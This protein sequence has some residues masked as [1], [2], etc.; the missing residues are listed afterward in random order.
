MRKVTFKSLSIRNFLSVGDSPVVIDFKDGINL[1]TGRNLDKPDAKNGAGKSTIID[2]LYFALFGTTIRE[3]KKDLIVN[4]I[5]K[6]NCEVELSIAIENGTETDEYLI[7]RKINPSKCELYLNGVDATKSTIANTTDFIQKLVKSSGEVFKNSVIMTINNTTPFLAQ[8][9]IEK[10]KFVENVV[11]LEVFSSMLKSARDEYNE[12]R[13]TYETIYTRRDTLSQSHEL[14]KQQL[15]LFEGNKQRRVKDLQEKIDSGLAN[16]ETLKKQLVSIP[17]DFEYLIGDKKKTLKESLAT[18]DLDYKNILEESSNIKAEIKQVNTQINAIN[19]K[20][21]SCPTC[22]RLYENDDSEHREAIKKDLKENLDGLSAKESEIKTKFEPFVE[23]REDINKKLEKLDS[24]IS[25]IKSKISNNE[26]IEDK[27]GY[28]KDTIESYRKDISKIEKESNEVLEKTVKDTEIKL[29]E[30][31]TELE[32][33]D[34]NLN[35]LDCIKFVVSEEGVKSYIVKKILAVLNQ[36]MFYYLQKFEANCICKFN[37]LFEEEI[38]D[39]RKESKS[40]FNFSGGERKR[41]DLA[42]L[43]AFLDIRRMQGD[44]SFSTTFYDEL[45][46]SSLDDRGVELVLEVLRDRV[47]QFKENA[48]I[49]THRGSAITSKVDNTIC[50]EKKNGFSN[51]IEI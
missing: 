16:I 17:D 3:L 39:D 20:S 19:Q 26:K 2:A 45:L 44:V 18:I 30:Y 7:K 27:I 8:D 22:K 24:A 43:F 6:K 50:I 48:Y 28:T 46:D 42:C 34:K 23:K 5:N 21:S 38:V 10:R 4:S 1:I 25:D 9:K 36:K 49:V 11:N 51:L 47:D 35:I 14:N 32:T 33:M 29:S 15:S 40:Y 31:K 41:I 37:E 12:L 13:R